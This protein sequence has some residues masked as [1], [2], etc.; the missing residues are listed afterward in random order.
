M[1]STFQKLIGDLWNR[2]IQ[3]F[4]LIF[5]LFQKNCSFLLFF[6]ISKTKYNYLWTQCWKYCQNT[7]SCYFIQMIRLDTVQFN[8]L[9]FWKSGGSQ[10]TAHQCSSHDFWKR[11]GSCA[12]LGQQ[13]SF[14]WPEKDK[15]QACAELRLLHHHLSDALLSHDSQ[16]FLLCTQL[17]RLLENC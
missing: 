11:T 4:S 10:N 7:P 17:P 14:H 15:R 3:L 9:L 8:T 13:Q 1:Y 16:S 6:F 5:S 2:N 12:P